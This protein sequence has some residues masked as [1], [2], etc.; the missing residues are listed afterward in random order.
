MHHLAKSVKFLNDTMIEVLFQDGKVFQYDMAEWFDEYPQF[1]AL[2]DRKLFLSGHTSSLSIIWNDELD[3]GLET[4]YEEGIL[5]RTEE[6]PIEDI[7]GNEIGLARESKMISQSE[8]ADITGINQ[9]DISRI[10][11]GKANPSL[12]TLKRIAAGLGKRL[13]IRFVDE[14]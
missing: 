1:K 11:A 13:E 2:E 7:V 10:E 6:V 4:A 9:A 14:Q 3:M 8:L 5:V 12:K